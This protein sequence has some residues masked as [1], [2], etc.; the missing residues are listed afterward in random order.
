L[1]NGVLQDI[2]FNARLHPAKKISTLSEAQVKTLLDAIRG[3]LAE[4][5]DRGGRDTEKDLFGDPGGYKTLLCKHTVN[6]PCTVC[7]T[8]IRKKAY[9]GGSIYY[10]EQC[11]ES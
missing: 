3:T 9:M 11:Q 2:L 10:C 5:A 1:G 8:I 7:G 4:M 6:T